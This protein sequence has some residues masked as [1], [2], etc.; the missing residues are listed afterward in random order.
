ME[1]KKRSHHPVAAL[2]LVVE[3]EPHLSELACYLHFLS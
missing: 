3:L 1:A 2:G